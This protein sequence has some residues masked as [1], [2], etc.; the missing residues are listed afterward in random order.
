MLVLGV[1][2]HCELIGAAL[3]RSGVSVEAEEQ[4]ASCE[5]VFS[6]AGRALW[7]RAML[8]YNSLKD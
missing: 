3:T 4:M 1:R 7:A 6:M 5:L 8:S 2:G